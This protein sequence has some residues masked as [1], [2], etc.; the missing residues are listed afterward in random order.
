MKRFWLALSYI[1]P[2]LVLVT[3]AGLFGARW[4]HRS[5]YH[6]ASGAAVD[7]PS[8]FSEG[9]PN[10]VAAMFYSAWCGSC[11]VL[12]PKLQVVV[13]QFDGRAVEFT[14]FDF[15]MGQTESLAKKADALGVD[16]VYQAHKG[17]T[18]FMALIDRRDERE[19]GRITLSLS[20]DQIRTVIEEAIKTVSLPVEN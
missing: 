20:D 11:A 15:S 3:V 13:P 7:P 19:I 18:G 17:E 14:K 12:E 10:L 2:I 9:R 8:A 5:D 1:L 4:M 16:Q 6:V